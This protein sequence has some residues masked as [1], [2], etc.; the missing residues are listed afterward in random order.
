MKKFNLTLMTTALMTLITFVSCTKPEEPAPVAPMVVFSPSKEIGASPLYVIFSNSTT[1]A[2]TYTWD[3]GDGTTSNSS[4]PNHIF[5]NTSTTSVATY[6]VTLTCTGEGNTT[7]SETKKVTVNKVPGETNG[8]TT[9][10]FNPTKTY[11]TMTDQDGNI[12]KTIVIGTQTW[13]A[14]NLRTTKYNDGTQIPNVTDSVEWIGLTTTGAFCTFKNTTNEL[15]IATNGRLYN[16]AA[17]NTG[18][19]APTGW[20]M[21]TKAEFE[22]LVGYLGAGALEKLKEVGTTHWARTSAAVTNESGFTALP[23]GTRSADNNGM[24]FSQD[25]SYISSTLSTDGW[26]WCLVYLSSEVFI[27]NART[28]N[29]YSVRLVKN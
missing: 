29:G 13:M 9:A 11:G 19:L 1:G 5:T 21:P 8:L 28:T 26:V 25:F 4:N 14:E 12:Y 6:T 24:F 2:K 22:T 3:F 17:V 20:H 16:W 23:S 10:V 15:A 7:A 18:K 27:P